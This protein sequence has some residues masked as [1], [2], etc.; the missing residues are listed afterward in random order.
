[1]PRGGF[2]ENSGRKGGWQNAET[3]TIRV[4]KVFASR[5]LEIAKLLDSGASIEIVTES[6]LESIESVTKSKSE[7]NTVPEAELADDAIWMTTREAW[8]KLGRPKAWNTFRNTKVE[9]L[10]I[11]YGIEADPARKTQGKTDARWLKFLSGATDN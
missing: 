9:A 7:T 5:L 3:K 1:M 4:P 2:R 8:E 6:K 10:R 11:L